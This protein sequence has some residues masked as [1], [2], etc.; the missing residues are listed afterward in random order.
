M[1]MT[2]TVYSKS[3]CPECVFTKKYLET[4]NVS[5]IEKRVDKNEDYLEEVT[6]LGYRSLPVIKI[7]DDETFTGYRPEKL[8]NLVLAWQR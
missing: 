8:E 5:Y 7:D 2:I 3:G 4:E 6:L 1:K